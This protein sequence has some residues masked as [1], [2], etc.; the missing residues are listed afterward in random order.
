LPQD[1]ANDQNCQNEQEV[2]HFLE[3]YVLVIVHI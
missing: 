1:I 3:R 2:L